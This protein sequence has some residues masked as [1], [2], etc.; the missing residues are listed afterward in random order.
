[1]DSIRRA[2]FSLVVVVLGGLLSGACSV[3]Q[4][5]DIEF[6]NPNS[7][8]TTATT[9]VVPTPDSDP[10]KVFQLLSSSSSFA[11]GEVLSVGKYWSVEMKTW[12]R[13]GMVQSVGFVRKDGAIWR[14]NN[15]VYCVGGQTFQ[16]EKIDG[17]V[18]E[19][20]LQ[21]AKGEPVRAELITAADSASW[22]SRNLQVRP[23]LGV[24]VIIQ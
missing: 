6:H 3:N 15:G 9:P 24:S 1:M 4:G 14:N 11:D 8:S 7:P 20:L 10:E 21:F 19:D 22:S 2:F 17:I 13:V 23:G 18:R 16:P 5:G 12:C